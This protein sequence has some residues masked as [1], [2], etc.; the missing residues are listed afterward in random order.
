MIASWAVLLSTS[1]A[2]RLS[3]VVIHSKQQN[4][5]PKQLWL[6]GSKEQMMRHIVF[7][8]K[9]ALTVL[10][11]TNLNIV[12]AGSLWMEAWATPADLETFDLNNWWYE[13][14]PTVG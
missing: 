4:K 12:E 10:R 2:R 1:K 8:T 3:S 11:Y 5:K 6:T 7:Y 14:I 13:V 9:D